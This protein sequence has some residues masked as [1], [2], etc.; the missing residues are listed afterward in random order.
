MTHEISI[1]IAFS[2]GVFTFFTPCILPLIPSYI[3]FITGCSIDELL[4][5]ETQIVKRKHIRNI[6]IETLLFVLG[7][8]FVFISLGASASYI[9]GFLFEHKRIIEIVGGL[10]VI[11]FGIHITGIFRIK[12]LDHDKRVQL[13]Y[14]PSNLFGSFI[15]GI[16]FAI[17]W[18][19]CVGPIL[20]GIL[21]CA[22][23][24]DSVYKGIL[25]L[26]AY[27]FGLG[28]PF[29]I[30]GLFIGVFFS[31][32]QKLIKYSKVISILSGLLLVAVGAFIM[33]GNFHIIESMFLG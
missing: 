20:G 26:S 17:G 11:L 22:A 25:L 32:F 24:Q 29:I 16:T 33:T 7:F 4:N 27:S 6:F 5:K 1:L 23:V 21:A 30:A 9:G 19:P 2:A 31:F 8:S 12:Y 14:K 18:T 13:K 28:I 10:I 15:I 3:A